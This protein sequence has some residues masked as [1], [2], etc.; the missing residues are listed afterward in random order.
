MTGLP[1]QALGH[2]PSGLRD[3]LIL[4]FRKITRNFRERRWE[5]QELDGG[6]LCEVVYTILHGYLG[7]GNYAANA[8]KPSNFKTACEQLA[9]VGDKNTYKKSP[10]VTLPLVL[11]PLY[12]LRNNR[13]V[14]HVG[15]DVDAN[16]MDATYV[17]HTSQW[18]MAE[19]VRIFHNLPVDEAAKVVHG[20]VDRTLPMIWEVDGVTRLL[21]PK[22]PVPDQTLLR[23]YAANEAVPVEVLI[24]DLE[25]PDAS[26]Y[27]KVLGRLHDR[28]M[29][30]HNKSNRTATISPLGI[31]DVEDRLLRN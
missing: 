4:E 20:L 27:R 12:D 10:R 26:N 11:V 5:A 23:L 25:R 7:G 17:L 28:R 6:R 29:I 9:Q 8:S 30:E 3:E 19:L 31:T 13:G 16:E 14:G 21:D 15:G 18:I 2:L 1:T 22:L 24:R